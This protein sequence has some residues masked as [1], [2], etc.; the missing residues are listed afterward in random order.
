MINWTILKREWFRNTKEDLLAGA[1]VGLAL[2]PERSPFHH[3]WG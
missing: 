2:I 3:C 1:V